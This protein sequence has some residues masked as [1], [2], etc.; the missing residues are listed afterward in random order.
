M[1]GHL[2]DWPGW[3]A[4]SWEGASALESGPSQ[5]CASSCSLSS[6]RFPSLPLNPF[7]VQVDRSGSQLLATKELNCTAWGQGEE[8]GGEEGHRASQNPGGNETRGFREQGRG[9][10]LWLAGDARMAWP[11]SP[12]Q[13]AQGLPLWP[14]ASGEPGR[15]TFLSSQSRARS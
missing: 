7:L 8:A 1:T 13:G 5:A 6:G 3:R 12:E 10:G 15:D 2:R 9:P 4:A 14:A 11:E